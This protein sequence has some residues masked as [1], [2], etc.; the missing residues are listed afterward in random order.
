[1][2]ERE[3][4]VK[5]DLQI[6]LRSITAKFTVGRWRRPWLLNYMVSARIAGFWVSS[7]VGFVTVS[8]DSDVNSLCR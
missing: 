8:N 4:G 3:N 1:M 5:A 7:R 6:R 2:S